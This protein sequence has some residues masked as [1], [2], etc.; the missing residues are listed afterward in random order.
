MKW[1]YLKPGDIVDVIAPASHAPLEKLSA[2]TEWLHSLGLKTRL[3]EGMISPD[4]FFAAPL[5]IQFNQMKEALLS[6]S[7]AIWCLRGG[8]GSMRL[9]PLLKKMKAPKHSKLFVGFSDITS[10]HLFLNQEWNWPTLH[11]RTL[12]QLSL[13]KSQTPDRR[14]L[15]DLIF[16]EKTSVVFKKLKP[17][18]EMAMLENEITGKIAGGN[19][20]L[21]QASIGTSWELKAQGKILFIED[22]SERGYRIDR[23]LEQLLQ[24]RIIHKGLK[25][26]VI[27]DFTDGKE[28][29]GTD[30]TDVALTRFAQKVSYPVLKGLKCGHGSEYNYSLPFNT[31]SV[32][33]TG[34]KS[35]LHCQSGGE[36]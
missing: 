22:V 33:I 10:L 29:D 14:E 34:S 20:S 32:L 13:E 12:S 3:L 31:K 1:Q 25:A 4:A 36:I 19:L 6:D 15:K 11:G 35:Q 21:L 30:L 2:A 16:G 9:I 23:M 26:M 24:A 7:K 18:N 17:L 28:K 27:G 8:Y 5:E